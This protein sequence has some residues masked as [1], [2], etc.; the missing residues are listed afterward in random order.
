M[1]T[2]NIKK[3]EWKLGKTGLV[4]VISG[5]AVLLCLAFLL[6][7]GV[8]KNIDSYPEK[9]ASA[10]QRFLALFW[11]PSKV[12][13]AVKKPAGEDRGEDKSGMDLAF[14]DA[15]TTQKIPSIEQAPADS[16]TDAD[17]VADIIA[18]APPPPP[19]EP[20]R[21]EPVAPAEIPVAETKTDVSAAAGEVPSGSPTPYVVH[22]ASLKD[23]AK[24][25]QI[26]KTVDAMGYASKVV[27]VELKGKGT[28]YRVIAAEFENR[29]RAQAAADKISR[30]VKTQCII[31]P[32]EKNAGRKQ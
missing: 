4:L 21:E 18:R 23:R 22:V 1:G 28:W 29:A 15:L 19:P 16:K 10:P 30:K 14:H 7:V 17:V 32:V 8:G 12:A 5:M 26:S 24:A 20:R 13:V 2:G 27:K 3:F 11:R 6:G 25:A 31:R 9:I